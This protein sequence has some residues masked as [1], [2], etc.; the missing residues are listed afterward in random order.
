MQITEVIFF[1][2]TSV[3]LSDTY[4]GIVYVSRDKVF[5][6]VSKECHIHIFKVDHKVWLLKDH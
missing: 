2:L 1:V 6:F 3:D 4:S 5:N